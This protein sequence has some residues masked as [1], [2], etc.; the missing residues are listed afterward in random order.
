M[1]DDLIFLSVRPHHASS[2]LLF[3]PGCGHRLDDTA[4][5]NDE[6]RDRNDHQDERDGSSDAGPAIPPSDICPNA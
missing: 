4:L 1:Q 6:E 2:L 5:G 3:H